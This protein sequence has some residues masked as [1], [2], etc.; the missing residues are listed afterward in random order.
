MSTGLRILLFIVLPILGIMLWPP[1]TLAGGLFVIPVIIVLF[2]LLGIMEWQG[3]KWALTLSI[4][5]QGINVITRLM[6]FI[7][8]AV[9]PANA[10]GGADVPLI[11][12]SI[13]AIGISLWL[14]LRLDK[15]D[16]QSTMTR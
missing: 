12:T 2:I 16:V 1:G 11:I 3:R 6:I 13:L 14:L 9:R 7:S 4:F 8:H 15:V 5:L 10:G